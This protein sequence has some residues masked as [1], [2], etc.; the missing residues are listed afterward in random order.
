MICHL[1]CLHCLRADPCLGGTRYTL[2]E[3]CALGVTEIDNEGLDRPSCTTHL[4]NRYS[5]FYLGVLPLSLVVRVVEGSL[6]A[7]RHLYPESN[8]V[9]VSSKL[10]TVYQSSLMPQEKPQPRVDEFSRDL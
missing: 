5:R 2:L 7:A 8:F 10:K 4:Y 1:I 3:A 6:S 9:L